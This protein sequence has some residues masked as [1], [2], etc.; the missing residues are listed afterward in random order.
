MIG[1]NEFRKIE[2]I[3]RHFL[4]IHEADAVY[5]M[6]FSSETENPYTEED[7]I[8]YIKWCHKRYLDDKDTLFSSWL[9]ESDSHKTVFIF[10]GSLSVLQ[11]LE[12]SIS[13]RL[14]PDVS[15]EEALDIAEN[16]INKHFLKILH[17]WEYDLDVK[18][19]HF[20]GQNA[21]E[22]AQNAINAYGEASDFEDSELSGNAQGFTAFIK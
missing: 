20:H 11:I 18:V 22:K 17:E 10:I 9:E 13:Q 7:I 1:E 15:K 3:L 5:E 4:S 14:L 21:S 8:N 6:I 2:A 12:T 16:V 19:L